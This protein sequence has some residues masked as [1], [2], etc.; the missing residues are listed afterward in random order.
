MD[1][2]DGLTVRNISAANGSGP[3]YATFA[4]YSLLEAL[5]LLHGGHWTEA[6]ETILW[7]DNPREWKL[8]FASDARFIRAAFH[9]A[10]AIPDDIRSEIDTIVTSADEEVL[11]VAHKPD[12]EIKDQLGL[13][14]D[15]EKVPPEASKGKPTMLANSRGPQLDVLFY[16]RWRL[17]DGWLSADA[18]KSA[19]EIH[20]DALAISM[21]KAVMGWLYP[22]RPQLT[23]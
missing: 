23:V 12:V 1:E 20:H 15:A 14:P 10:A 18:A 7:R 22:S 2:R 4:T 3:A 16:R 6:A 17:R 8:D 19:L 11:R 5:G 21:R 13:P 9:A